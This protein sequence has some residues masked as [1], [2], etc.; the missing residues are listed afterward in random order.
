[1]VP[2]GKG[3]RI[4]WGGK[5]CELMGMKFLLVGGDKKILE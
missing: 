3:K 2:R 1:M 5:E 4:E